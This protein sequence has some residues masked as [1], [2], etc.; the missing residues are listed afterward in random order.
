MIQST[1]PRGG[2]RMRQMQSCK[3]TSSPSTFH[4]IH[5]YTP[6]IPI[7]WGCAWG[8]PHPLLQFYCFLLRQDLFRLAEREIGPRAIKVVYISLQKK[9]K[10][11]S[12][13]CFFVSPR[14]QS[15][16]IKLCAHQ[17]RPRSWQP[18]T[19]TIIF[20]ALN[21]I[22]KVRFNKILWAWDKILGLGDD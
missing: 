22:R 11:V 13:D 12:L 3:F 9:N 6:I 15:K 20:L 10:D 14:A 16:Q 7:W 8:L 2:A 1:P 19:H 21:G 4:P 17:M 18:Q 5:H